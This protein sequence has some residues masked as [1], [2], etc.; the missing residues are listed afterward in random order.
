LG[1]QELPD[2]VARGMG[3]VLAESVSQKEI[4]S[5]LKLSANGVDFS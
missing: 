4:D 3:F 1:E 2:S 5:N